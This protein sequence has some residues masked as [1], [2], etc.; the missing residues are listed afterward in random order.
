M[1][2]RL[3]R[4]KVI[5]TSTITKLKSFYQNHGPLTT[6]LLALFIVII[7]SQIFLLLSKGTFFGVQVHDKRTPQ[8]EQESN[9][10][11]NSTCQKFNQ[12]AVSSALGQEVKPSPLLIPDS[13]NP[14]KISSCSY[15]TVDSK[16]KLRT[17]SI[18]I[19]DYSS[20]TSAKKSIELLEKRGKGERIQGVQDEAYF[21]ASTG[22]MTARKGTVL[23]TITVTPTDSADFQPSLDVA[24][25][26]IESIPH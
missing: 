11:K 19:K 12:Q 3:P 9:Y 26:L 4:D 6:V 21:V 2:T 22:Q 8:S 1:K 18:I 25:K 23:T 10:Y 20:D 14:K 7:L 17:V 15:V 13:S 16:P 24:K 5:K